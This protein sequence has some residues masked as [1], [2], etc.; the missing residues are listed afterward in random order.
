ME[1]LTEENWKDKSQGGI[2]W[3]V[4]PVKHIDDLP[5]YI[6]LAE[7]ED[8]NLTPEQM[9]QIDKAFRE[10]AKELHDWQENGIKLP[11]KVGTTVYCRRQKL[12]SDIWYTV[13]DFVTRF[14]IKREGVFAITFDKQE[15][16]IENFGKT[17]FLT[18]AEAEAKLK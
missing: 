17:I 11:C 9:R 10:Q 13:E 18:K 3:N 7:F 12:I 6:K 1:R 15:I 4:H 16:P 2:P 14:E 5:Y 8:T